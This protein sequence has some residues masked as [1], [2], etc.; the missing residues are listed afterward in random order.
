MSE[1]SYEECLRRQ[2]QNRL[3]TLSVSTLIHKHCQWLEST[4]GYAKYPDLVSCMAIC[5]S[6]EVPIFSP[7]KSHHSAYF[8]DN[9][10][11][12]DVLIR[13]LIFLL[14]PFS[15]TPRRPFSAMDPKWTN[16]EEDGHT[17]QL[18]DAAW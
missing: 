13:C 14:A 8:T 7:A 2:L 11:T 3:A 12:P 4:S 15:C 17:M 6:A 5:T 18:Y 10:P 9:S 1:D 16:P